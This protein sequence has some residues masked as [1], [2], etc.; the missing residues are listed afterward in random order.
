MTPLRHQPDSSPPLRL[1]LQRIGRILLTLSLCWFANSSQAA[2]SKPEPAFGVAPNI[3]IILTDDQGYGELSCHGNPFLQ[4]PNLDRLHSRSVRFTD[5]H[6]SPTCA[7]TRAALLTGRHEFRSGV[8]HTVFER[9]RLSLS[10]VTLA[11]VLQLNGYQTGIFGK[12]HLGDE[13]DY[14]PG[15]RGFGEVFIHGGGGIGQTYPGSCGDIPRNTYHQ[16]IVRHNAQFETTKGYC[17]D[18]FFDAAWRWMDARRSQRQRFFAL[19][20]PN[21]PH[22]PFITPDSSWEKPFREKGLDAMTS[23]YYAMIANIDANLGRLMD[24]LQSSGME[25][26]T[27]VIFMT[28]NGHGMSSLYN[29]GM[30][31]AKGG[32][33]QGGT[34]VP[35]FWRWKGTLPEGIDCPR[36][37]AHIDLFP[38]L[39]EIA[40]CSRP[41]VI[42]DRPWPALEGRS[43]VPL[44]RSPKAPWNDR[45]LFIHLGRWESG[46]SAT[47]QWSQTAVR[48]AQYRMVN[49]TELYDIQQDPGESRDIAAA[50][51]GVL[52]E[53]RQAHD[54][55]WHSVLP[56]ALENEDVVGPP[57][58]PYKRDYW[59]AHPEPRDPDLL[60]RM[61]PALKFN[62][63]RPRL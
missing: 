35:S 34:R 42:G 57:I 33:Y 18:V 3:L 38:T 40:G 44:L 63:D 46:Q 29:A 16:P 10:A 50:H 43:L 61:N 47:A 36:L 22:D 8:T 9:E 4:T 21:A 58:N 45:Q 37:S 27:L 55:W 48:T 53:L 51:P 24:R 30:R 13:P 19:L 59:E 11:E 2:P 49:G 5:F 56:S 60:W 62:P 32:P 1:R 15:R 14:Q 17:T 23:A 41:S 6:V 20:T 7:P 12:W 39:L 25:T 26:N 54:A 52:R 31:G 28:D